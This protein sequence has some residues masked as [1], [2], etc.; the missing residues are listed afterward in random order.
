LI[1]EILTGLSAANQAVSLV[2]ELREIDRTVD[3]ASF[4]LKL[5]E[6]S[7]ALADTRV[8]LSEAKTALS[9]KD[10]EI[11]EIRRILAEVEYGETCKIC[12]SGTLQVIDVKPHPIR[13]AELMGVQ[14][15]MLQCDNQECQHGEKKIHD[16]NGYLNSK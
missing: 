4:K 3:D 10:Q 7:E 15:W 6:L 2:K 16:P 13:R 5:A 14:D 1:S 9:E 11:S 12:W 8:A